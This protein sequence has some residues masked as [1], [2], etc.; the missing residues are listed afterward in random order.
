MER[1]GVDRVKRSSCPSQ[2]KPDKAAAE[3]V[4]AATGRAI[5]EVAQ[6]AM[7]AS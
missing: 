7:A 5:A 4:R 2:A 1:G 3:A 6:E